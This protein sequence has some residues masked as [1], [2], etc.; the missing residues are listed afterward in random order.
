M[1]SVSWFCTGLNLATI[2]TCDAGCGARVQQQ[3]PTPPP[4]GFSGPVVETTVTPISARVL[5]LPVKEGSMPLF[6]LVEATGGVRVVD[7]TTKDLLAQTTAPARSIVSIDENRGIS[8]G[9]ILFTPGPLPANHRYG[10]YFYGAGFNPEQDIRTSI[11]RIDPELL[12]S[13]NQTHDQPSGKAAGSSQDTST[14]G[15]SPHQ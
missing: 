10:I 12:N 2:A 15:P 11:E 1:N 4:A 14:T 9:G 3:Q 13:H 5:D 7:Q 8:I 6:Y